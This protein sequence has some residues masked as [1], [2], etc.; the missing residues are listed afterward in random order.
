MLGDAPGVAGCPSGVAGGLVGTVG[1]ACGVTVVPD[2]GCVVD[3]EVVEGFCQFMG[4]WSGFGM[5][6]EVFGTVL[7][8]WPAFGVVDVVPGKGVLD[9]DCVADGV[10]VDGIVPVL[11]AAEGIA[12][13]KA[14]RAAAA[15][16]KNVVLGFIDSS[17]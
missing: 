5:V 6:L 2:G 14:N 11:W 10:E 13:A 16:V 9:G 3:G 1:S 12:K 17:S 8:I 7:G 15:T 4:C